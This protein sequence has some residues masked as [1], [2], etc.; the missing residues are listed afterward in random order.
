MLPGQTLGSSSH[1]TLVVKSTTS[2]EVRELPDLQLSQPEHPEKWS[3][4]LDF[5]PS[6]TELVLL[7]SIPRAEELL[8]NILTFKLL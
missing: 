4:Q 8:V 6:K 1:Q 5:M 3:L 7:V 2:T